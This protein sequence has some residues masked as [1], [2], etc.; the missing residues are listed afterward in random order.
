[1]R[2]LSAVE[3]TKCMSG[4]KA[5]GRKGGHV[6]TLQPWLEKLP[7]GPIVFPPTLPGMESCGVAGQQKT[8]EI[9]SLHF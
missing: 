6:L 3:C 4:M 7:R 9:A 1:M 8:P 5:I 2:N